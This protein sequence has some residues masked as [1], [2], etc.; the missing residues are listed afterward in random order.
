MAQRLQTQLGSMRTQVYPWAHS[1]GGLRIW[2]CR[3]LQMQLRSHVAL[4]VALSLGTY[5]CHRFSPKKEKKRNPIALNH[6]DLCQK[7]YLQLRI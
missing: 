1:V 5:I 3:E 2:H 6:S 4:A 7:Y